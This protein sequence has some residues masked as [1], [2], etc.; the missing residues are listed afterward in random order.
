MKFLIVAFH[1]RT[2]TPY[3]KQYEDEIVK[4][5]HD[6]DVVF[7]DRFSNANLEKNKNEFIF[8][9]ICSLGGN[10]LKKIYPF[11]LFRKNVKN[12]IKVGKYDKII[13]LNTMP[14]FLLQDVLKKRYANNFILD[15]RDYTYEKYKIYHNAV[16]QLIE[17]SYFTAISS[18]GFIKFL[19]NS[20]KLVINH[21]IHSG[22]GSD[23]S[24]FSFDG[25]HK[26]TIGF[27]GA[28]RYFD[29]NSKLIDYLYNSTK[30]RLLYIGRQ[31][32]DCNLQEYCHNNDY[33]NI[34]FQGEFKNEDK[35]QIYQQIDIINSIYGNNSVE[36]TT[37]IPNKLYDSLVFKKPILVSK[38]TYLAK[39]VERYHI[40]IAVDMNNI[41]K[42][43]DEYIKY[44]DS[45]Q[46]NIN[47]NNLLHVVLNEQHVFHKKIREFIK[48]RH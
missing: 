31:N 46:F 9:R 29:L 25:K 15:I 32:E 11:Y 2:M 37:A 41:E 30:Y 24:H 21:N 1:P 35:P 47:A 43:I 18:R 23:A 5:G 40:G 4:A 3:A 7:W 20:E 28:I 17:E 45:Y 12:I 39:I 36:V 22:I 48:C 26:I 6:Y 19:G 16:R 14:G 33:A 27:V 38:G 13:I 42:D 8:H 44:F 10:R 34:K